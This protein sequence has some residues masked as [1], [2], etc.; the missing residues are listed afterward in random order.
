MFLCLR[1]GPRGDSKLMPQIL[2]PP[3]ALAQGCHMELS[4][5][6]AIPSSPSFLPHEQHSTA[7]AARPSLSQACHMSRN[8]RLSSPCQRPPC[9]RPRSILEP[10][11]RRTRNRRSLGH[12]GS[13]AGPVR[14]GSAAPDNHGVM[15][16]G[17]SVRHALPLSFASAS[18]QRGPW[19]VLH[20]ALGPK[21]EPSRTDGACAQRRTVPPRRFANTVRTIRLPPAPRTRPMPL[22]RSVPRARRLSRR[23]AGDADRRREGARRVVRTRSA[24]PVTD[25]VTARR[26][27]NLRVRSAPAL[28]GLVFLCRG[29]TNGRYIGAKGCAGADAT[30]SHTED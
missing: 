5:A 7:S 10:V 9:S 28:L 3:P 8:L 6:H 30:Q 16:R 25:G 13:A 29:R 17:P 15:R 27:A 2:S 11:L 1:M 26:G 20:F 19:A 24:S 14:T 21:T 22:P 12:L 4:R 18:V 23:T